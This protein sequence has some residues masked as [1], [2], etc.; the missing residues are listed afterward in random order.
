[1][2]PR[3]IALAVAL[4]AV[5]LF[6]TP[7]LFP[8]P[9]AAP[10]SGV[11][12]PDSSLRAD[13]AVASLA[14]A[15][16]TVGAA[17]SAVAASATPAQGAA[18]SAAAPAVD[19]AAVAIDTAAVN[20]AHAVYRTTNR[21]VAWQEIGNFYRVESV[22]VDPTNPDL[23]Y[24]S[25]EADGLWITNNLRSA[26]PTFQLDR[27]YPFQH[28]TRVFFNPFLPSQVWATSFGG[29]LRLLRLEQP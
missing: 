9:P 24:V 5:V 11:V 28:P 23:A 21:G 1:M 6:L 16:P 13:S 27:S 10:G 18:M 12:V 7:M 26:T 4:M 8:T 19:S 2:E 22:S 17:A 29:G 20:T 14:A 15:S 3:R 25:T